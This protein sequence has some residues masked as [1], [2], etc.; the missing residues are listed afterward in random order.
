MMQNKNLYTM[1]MLAKFCGSGFQSMGFESDF[2][3]KVNDTNVA[4]EAH[5][6]KTPILES[7]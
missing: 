7:L 1:R 5:S 2:F 4:F 3:F 6:L